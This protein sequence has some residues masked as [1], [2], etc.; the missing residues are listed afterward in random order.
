MG[1]RAQGDGK[2]NGGG[3]DKLATP[4]IGSRESANDGCQATEGILPHTAVNESNTMSDDVAH[5][6]EGKTQTSP[7]SISCLYVAWFS[8]LFFLG[9]LR[10]LGSSSVNIAA[11]VQEGGKAVAGYVVLFFFDEH[12]CVCLPRFR[13]SVLRF[14]FLLP[15]VF[16]PCEWP[17]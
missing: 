4:L 3:E 9:G 15:C 6:V 2:Q 13:F 10:G 17:L 8:V 16:F 5:I 12:E 7:A 1:S 14:I 11:A